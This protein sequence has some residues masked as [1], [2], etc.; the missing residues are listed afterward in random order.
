M[1]DAA[2]PHARVVVDSARPSGR[3]LV[4]DGV[5]ASYVDLADPT[6][7]EFPYVRRLA[8]VVDVA[9]PTGR[10]L[11]V[12]H[13][14]GGGCTLPRYVA[15]TR[16]GSRADVV[17]LH[18]DVVRLARE[19]LGA[20]MRIRTGDAR[21]A[22]EGAP[23]RHYDLVVTDVFHGPHVPRHLTTADFLDHVRRVLRPAGVYAVNLIDEKPMR[24]AQRA[25]ATVLAAFPE[26]VLLAPRT[27]LA[28]RRTGNL[29]VAA[30]ARTLPLARLQKASGDWDVLDREQA[31]AW[32]AGA[33]TLRD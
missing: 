11:D 24:L 9:A 14:G 31:E 30:A 20:A 25:T 23:R 27:V 6:H 32:C 8:D 12:L 21:A 15:A 3:T 10:A 17:E 29:V 28:G 1:A 22:V 33:K 4:L 19:E 16:P 2:T 13:L 5:E 26:T 7:L 18:P